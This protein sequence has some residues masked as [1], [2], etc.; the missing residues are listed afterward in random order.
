MTPD[1]G[2]VVMML[3]SDITISSATTRANRTIGISGILII[4]V[5]GVWLDAVGYYS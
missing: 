5:V 2:E 4:A 3:H 1:L